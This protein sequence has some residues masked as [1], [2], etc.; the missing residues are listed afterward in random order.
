MLRASISIGSPV[1]TFTVSHMTIATPVVHPAILKLARSGTA[2]MSGKPSASFTQG[3][4]K[5]KQV[6]SHV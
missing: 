5:M 3:V 2:C 4:E 6:G 1:V